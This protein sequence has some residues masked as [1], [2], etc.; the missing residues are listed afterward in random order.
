MR[1]RKGRQRGQETSGWMEASGKRAILKWCEN[2]KL[3]KAV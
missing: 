2:T 1:V 3:K